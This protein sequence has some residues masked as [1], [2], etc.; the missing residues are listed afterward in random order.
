MIE[1]KKS[2]LI[3]GPPQVV[4]DHLT[5]SKYIEKWW[6]KGIFLEALLGGK[7]H[8]P[9]QDALGKHLATGTV[10]GLKNYEFISFT[11]KEDSWPKDWKTSVEIR[12]T[13]QSSGSLIGVKHTGWAVFPQDERS[14]NIQSFSEGWEYLL[15]QLK[16]SVE[17]KLT[18]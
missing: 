10:T 11:W 9:W 2:I 17:G 5:N 13:L 18:E 6:G 12:L 14:S 15:S 4:W 7:F 16:K 3:S 1:I 8:E